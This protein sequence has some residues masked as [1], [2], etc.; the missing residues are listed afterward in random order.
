MGFQLRQEGRRRA[1]PSSG[2]IYHGIDGGL[3]HDDVFAVGTDCLVG[4]FRDW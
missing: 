1:E 2:F 4:G 3:Y